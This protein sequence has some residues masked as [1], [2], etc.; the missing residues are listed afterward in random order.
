MRTSDRVNPNADATGTSIMFRSTTGEGL[1]Q[2][3]FN[4][5]I[6]LGK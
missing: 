5:G 6:T 2:V 3:A 1:T 4:L